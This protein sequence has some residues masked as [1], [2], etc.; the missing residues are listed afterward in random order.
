MSSQQTSDKE[1]SQDS[2]IL[3]M[4]YYDLLNTRF[5]HPEA[6]SRI[7]T[8]H[9]SFVVDVANTLL[10]QQEASRV[11]KLPDAEYNDARITEPSKPTKNTLEDGRHYYYEFGVGR[12]WIKTKQA[13]T[14]YQIDTML[15]HPIDGDG[16]RPTD[17]PQMRVLGAP[18]RIPSTVE[19]M[20]SQKEPLPTDAPASRARSSA[21]GGSAYFMAFRRQT[22]RDENANHMIV[23]N[24]I[25]RQQY[26]ETWHEVQT[27]S[28]DVWQGSVQC[29]TYD[30]P[31]F[32]P[33][34]DIFAE[35]VSVAIASSAASR[36]ESARPGSRRTA[37]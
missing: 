11:S 36:Q 24:D 7:K 32:E 6:G 21:S 4:S 13:S 2:Q 26:Q 34:D 20:R 37:I 23:I 16:G 28:T 12:E 3:C 35:S 5:D 25:P 15:C 1:L 9:M 18:Q 10:D 27:P 14:Y 33:I 22:M 31:N 19:A 30:A 29:Q 8:P 17:V